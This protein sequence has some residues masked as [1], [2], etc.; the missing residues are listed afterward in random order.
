MWEEGTAA[1]WRQK[2]RKWAAE[3]CDYSREKEKRISVVFVYTFIKKVC[4][5]NVRKCVSMNW[6]SADFSERKG[7]I[8]SS[9]KLVGRVMQ[10]QSL[11]EI[12]FVVFTRTYLELMSGFIRTN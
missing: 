10:R 7:Q 9:T 3:R 2:R 8:C 5:R 12:F 4:E 11:R 6:C 1:S